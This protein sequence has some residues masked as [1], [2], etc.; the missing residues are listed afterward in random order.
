LNKTR[1]RFFPDC[2]EI[3]L[4]D[5]LTLP[6]SLKK[7]TYKCRLTYGLDIINIEFEPYS[8]KNI[9]FLKIVRDNQI[10]Y[11][12]KYADRSQINSL[13]HQRYDCDDVLIIKNNR[14]TDSSYCNIIFWDGN[15]WITPDT[16]LLE[17]TRRQALIRNGKIHEAS[18]TLSDL[19]KLKKFKL[20]NSMRPFEQIASHPIKNIKC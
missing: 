10:E 19:K 1:R 2:D 5:I 4:A 16:P 11:S 8:I 12:F 14:I 3:N 18:I 6:E 7:S 13:F 15:N 9:N 17:G 20:I